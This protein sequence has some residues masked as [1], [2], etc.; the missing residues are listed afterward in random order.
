MIEKGDHVNFGHVVPP[1]VFGHMCV[2]VIHVC[3]LHI[4]VSISVFFGF[5]SLLLMGFR[6]V[7]QQCSLLVP[8]RRL[9]FKLLGLGFFVRL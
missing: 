1:Y 7:S 9:Q 5:A 4:R 2:L 8:L 6:E 3:F